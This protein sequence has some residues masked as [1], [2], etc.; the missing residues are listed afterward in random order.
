MRTEITAERTRVFTPPPGREA[1][2]WD[3]IVQGLGLR[4]R[5]TGHRTWIVHRRLRGGVVKRTLGTPDALTIDDARRDAHAL[6]AGVAEGGDTPAPLIR[7]FVPAFL[8]DCRE[9]WKPA[10]RASHAQNLHGQVLPAFGARRVDSITPRDV[11]SWFDEQAATRPASAN[12]ALAVLS[13]LMKHAEALGLRP[14]GSNPCR[15]LRRHK[16]SFE[17]RYLNDD[18]FAAL[19]RALDQMERVH[20]VA[21][22]ALRFLLYTGARKS[23]ALGLKWEH[24]HDDRAVLPDSKPGPRTIWLA[25]PARALLA[26]LPR[27][28]DCPWVFA[29]R[30]AKPVPIE[31]AWKA[32]RTAAGLEGMRIHD[33]RHNFAAVAVGSGEGLRIVAD[34]LGH[35]DIKTT[36]GY[37]H[38]AEST[39]YKAADRV[40]RILADALDGTGT[41]RG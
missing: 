7:T 37:T 2:L 41:G 10:T 35:A 32:V 29:S 40:S 18:E 38:L 19:G 21:I 25:A 8:D 5:S 22:A 39:V 14:E 27:R 20:P 28:N 30:A 3:S 12:R 9:R 4:V 34:L 16:S 36:F 13:V 31:K 26:T 17:A 23:E 33:C 24:V 1:V 11:R 6:I 15:G